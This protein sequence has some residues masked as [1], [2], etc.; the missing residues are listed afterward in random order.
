MRTIPRHFAVAIA[1]ALVAYLIAPYIARYGYSLNMFTENTPVDGVGSVAA[2][3]TGCVWFVFSLI[4]RKPK[5]QQWLII[6]F[7]SPVLSV[8]L[9]YQ[10]TA[11]LSDSGSH[12]YGFGAPL[13]VGLM[14]AGM[15]C[16]IFVPFGLL[17]GGVS[18]FVAKIVDRLMQ[19]KRILL[20]N[21]KGSIG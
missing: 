7:F 14:V 6:G 17:T 4:L 10:L 3:V 19:N 20:S 21:R 5:L 13:W 9:F 16:W 15:F 1:T 12:S 11:W 2:V 18:G 8:P